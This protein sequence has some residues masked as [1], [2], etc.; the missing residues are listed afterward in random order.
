MISSISYTQTCQH[1]HTLPKVQRVLTVQILADANILLVVAVRGPNS[2]FFCRSPSSET[3]EFEH[4]SQTMAP[5]PPVDSRTPLLASRFENSYS[6]SP[7]P[8]RP[9]SSRAVPSSLHVLRRRRHSTI[10]FLPAFFTFVLLFI[11]AFLA[12]DVSSFGNCYFAPVC[13]MLGDG[14]ERMGSVWWRDAGAYA[15]WKSLGSGGGKRGLPRGCEIN[16]VN[17]VSKA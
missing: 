6:P 17:L 16:Q 12:W 8:S 1:L 7:G 5:L 13:R 15:P 9:F 2:D 10:H 4:S 11:V 3:L 14:R